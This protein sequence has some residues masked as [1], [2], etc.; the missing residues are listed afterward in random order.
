MKNNNPYII[1]LFAAAAFI[2]MMVIF[3]RMGVLVLVPVLFGSLPIYIAALG[4]GTVAGIVATVTIVIATT[5]TSG[6]AGGLMIAMIIA[7]PA[8][9]AGHQANL[10][11]RLSD[12]PDDLAWYPL[13]RI[14]FWI[15][16][17]IAAAVLIFGLM[18]DFDPN[19]LGPQLAQQLKAM[20]PSGGNG[21][22]LSQND[23]NLIMTQNLKILPF[24]LPSLWIGI[25]MMNLVLGL[26]ITRAMGVL[27]RPLENIA[28]ELNMPQFALGLMVVTLVGMGV[29]S[30]PIS[31]VFAVMSGA[32]VMAFSIVGL[33]NF[34]QSIANWPARTPLLILTYG[35]I[36][37]VFFPVYLFSIAGVLRASRIPKKQDYEN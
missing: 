11:Q 35:V 20:I 18:L 33:A 15:A 12:D 9:L 25:H 13:S 31:Y 29:T 24:I 34:H 4:W 30:A 21:P 6:A 36:A 19:K 8:A 7:A 3:T 27:A 16:I 28:A 23:L 1:G 14:L 37:I 2:A 26:R 5:M 10:A 32:L 17:L 22:A